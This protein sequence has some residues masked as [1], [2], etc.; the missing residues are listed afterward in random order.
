MR[1]LTNR[2]RVGTDHL[3]WKSG[4]VGLS[5][6]LDFEC[7]V[8]SVIWSVDWSEFLKLI[9]PKNVH[10]NEK[11]KPENAKIVVRECLEFKTDVKMTLEDARF[12]SGT[13]KKS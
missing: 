10:H 5:E 12:S 13:F 6:N 4:R 3:Y 8:G 9:W 2:P 7:R 11:I 1:I